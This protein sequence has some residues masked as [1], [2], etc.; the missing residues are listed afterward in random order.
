MK[1]DKSEKKTGLNGSELSDVFLFDKEYL[2]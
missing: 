2:N 1:L